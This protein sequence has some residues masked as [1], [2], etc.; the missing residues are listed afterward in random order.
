M[1]V[2][3]RR[4]TLSGLL[5]SVL[6]KG[7]SMNTYRWVANTIGAGVSLAQPAFVAIMLTVAGCA[8]AAAE[9]PR[10]PIV[11]ELAQSEDYGD[12]DRA[13]EIDPD[14]PEAADRGTSR[15]SPSEDG[16]PNA[17]RARPNVPE[18][19]AEPPGC[20]LRDGPLELMV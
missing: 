10:R 18:G 2:N 9:T 20:A 5:T 14:A 12:T 3:D 17:N 8:G 7:R 16:T 19:D 15:P 1:K 13:F 11:L 4:L 6:T